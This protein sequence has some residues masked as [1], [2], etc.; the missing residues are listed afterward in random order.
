MDIFNSLLS[1]S[2]NP[3]K[4]KLEQSLESVIIWDKISTMISESTGSLIVVPNDARVGNTSSGRITVEEINS[5]MKALNVLG[6]GSIDS[7]SLNAN[8]IFDW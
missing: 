5:L 6:V 4:N 8:F 3:N 2:D 7:V 1:A